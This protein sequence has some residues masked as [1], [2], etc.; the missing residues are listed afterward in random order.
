MYSREGLILTGRDM[1]NTGTPPPSSEDTDAVAHVDADA[2]EAVSASE[3]IC[4]SAAQSP[5][6]P[7]RASKS[8]TASDPPLSAW[9]DGRQA[10]TTNA[11][12]TS[13]CVGTAGGAGNDNRTSTT[14]TT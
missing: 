8:L 5:I 2:R 4:W 11:C 13:S 14:T 10:R 1:A 6:G 3:P 9:T 12:S 7:A